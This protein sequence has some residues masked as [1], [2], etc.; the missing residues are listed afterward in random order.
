VRRDKEVVASRNNHLMSEITTLWDNFTTIVW[1]VATMYVTHNIPFLHAQIKRF[2]YST[3]L[4]RQ[5]FVQILC[6]VDL[7]LCVN[8]WDDQT[9]PN[10]RIFW[11]GP[12][13]NISVW[14]GQTQ[15]PNKKN[16]WF[17]PVNTALSPWFL[18]RHE[19]RVNHP[20][21]LS[22]PCNLPSYPS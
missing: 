5:L 3:R 9:T 14:C 13:G 21:L 20:S 4:I 10:D 22:K 17:T 19:N 6:W 2:Y 12:H 1:V 7:I 8:S 15:A 11:V 16:V 18:L